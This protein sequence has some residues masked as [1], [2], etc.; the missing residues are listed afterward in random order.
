MPPVNLARTFCFVCEIN[1]DAKKIKKKMKS[2]QTALRKAFG[3]AGG[4]AHDSCSFETW[5]GEECLLV[6]SGHVEKD[7]FAA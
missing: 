3:E 5:N 7:L 6:K 4:I 2:K 1:S